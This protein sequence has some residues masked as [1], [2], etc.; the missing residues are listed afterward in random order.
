MLSGGVP[1]LGA[2]SYTG[3]RMAAGAKDAIKMKLAREHNARYAQYALPTE[4]PSRDAL[5]A[6]L[7]SQIPGPKPSLISRGANTLSRIV[8][9]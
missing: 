8:A 3:A 9:P 5:I 4:G 2:A 1:L 6:A 7:E